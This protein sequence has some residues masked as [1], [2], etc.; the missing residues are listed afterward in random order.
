M[1]EMT[2][3]QT[4][5]LT[6]GKLADKLGINLETIRFY[7]REGLIK[8]PAKRNNGFRYY[9]D[10][11][12]AKITFILKAKELGFTLS[13]IKD[14][15]QINSQRKA[16]CAEVTLKVNHKLSEIDKSQ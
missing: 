8:E 1:N 12:L 9:N 16:S 11:H 2:S 14:F 3:I 7:Q 15:L 13:E 10:D 4:S 5:S 6:I